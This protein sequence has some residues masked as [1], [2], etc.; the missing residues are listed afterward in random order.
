M[1]IGVVYSSSPKWP[2]M[3]WV[4]RA[5]ENLGHQCVHIHE[6][7]ALAK[8][9]GNCD[10]ILFQHKGV[11]RWPNLKDLCF[12]RKSPWVQWWFD[13]V[14]AN[15]RDIADPA[16]EPLF[17]QYK[18]FMSNIDV[19]FFK[20]V[21]CLDS[22]REAGVNAFYLDQ[23]CPSHIREVDRS[24]PL[25]WDVLLWG[26]PYKSR[27]RAAEHLV[28]RKFTVA[29]ASSDG[30]ITDKVVRLPWCHPEELWK[31]AGR[32]RFVLSIDKEL[33]I[34]GY[35]SDRL[36]LACGMGCCVLQ[37]SFW[38]HDGPL[39]VFRVTR[40]IEPIIKR[41]WDNAESNG[42]AMR[43]WVM[44]EHT[45]EHRLLD[46]FHMLQNE[47]VLAD[48]VVEPGLHST[49]TDEKPNDGVCAENADT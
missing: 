1:R 41:S 6:R 32:A 34:D 45:I 35:T 4:C 29:W 21:A 33:H 2:K 22:Y 12:K 17:L 47:K 3:A 24:Q 40:E 20:E 14:R 31:L 23:G 5:I 27:T 30:N 48:S 13:L 43:E 39:N 10:F 9:D 36:W 26:Q 37:R 25:E 42:K 19:V 7:D 18:D 15:P 49:K 28:S 16:Q 38:Q 46:M 8:A 44:S 11:I